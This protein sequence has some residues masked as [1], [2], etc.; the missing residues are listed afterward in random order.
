MPA[1]S[2]P[3]SADRGPAPV[4][5]FILEHESRPDPEAL[6]GLCRW[7][8]GERERMRRFADPAARASYCLARALARSAISEAT[9]RDR[10][11]IAFSQPEAGKPFLPGD[12]IQFNWS[13]AAG[14]V[15]LAL[16]PGTPLGIDVEELGRKRIDPLRIARRFFSRREAAWIEEGGEAG[17]EER[18]VSLFV[19]KEAFLKMTGEG[20]SGSLEA[21]EAR[22][23]LPPASSET[24]LLGSFG[25]ERKYLFAIRLAGP[26]VFEPRAA[27]FDPA[28]GFPPL[29]SFRSLGA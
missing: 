29:S 19:Q 18:F 28:A 20:L 12:P 27:R 26:G 5:V 24:S 14:C 10:D 16:S 9:G 11:G 15:A 4:T 1:S 6:E 2:L 13:H 17:R 8:E 22:L 7:T 21:A 3:G 25:G 23:S